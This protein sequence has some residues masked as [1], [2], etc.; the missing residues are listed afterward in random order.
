[1]EIIVASIT[2]FLFA[3]VVVIH[4]EIPGMALIFL[5]AQ[6]PLAYMYTSTD[7]V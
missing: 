5:M 2:V 7:A 1:M 4:G 6:C 3:A